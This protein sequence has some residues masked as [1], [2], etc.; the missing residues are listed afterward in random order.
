MLNKPSQ[1]MTC[2]QRKTG[3]FTIDANGKAMCADCA[4]AANRPIED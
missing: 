3:L 2:K 1:C 4:R